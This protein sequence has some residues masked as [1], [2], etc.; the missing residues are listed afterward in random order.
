MQ[1]LYTDFDYDSIPVAD[2]SADIHWIELPVARRPQRF[3]HRN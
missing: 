2:L 1:K 3:P